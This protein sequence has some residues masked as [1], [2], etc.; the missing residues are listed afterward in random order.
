M[1]SVLAQWRI[2][3]FA[4]AW[5]R[6]SD[7]AAIDTVVSTHAPDMPFGLGTTAWRLCTAIRAHGLEAECVHGRAAEPLLRAHLATGAWAPVLLDDGLLGGRAFGAHWAVAT[8]ADAERVTLGNCRVPSLCWH[9]FRHI[10]R[11]RFLPPP[12]RY[13]TIL[14]HARSWLDPLRV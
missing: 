6:A 8:A 2:G 4:H 1:A 11:C 13:C 14:T 5:A 7:A 12:H 10:W 3:P 9:A